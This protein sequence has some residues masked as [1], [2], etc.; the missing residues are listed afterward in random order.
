M[1]RSKPTWK[2]QCS[3]FEL[4]QFLLCKLEI[5]LG[6]FAIFRRSKYLTY[7]Q[8][9]PTYS[10]VYNPY[11]YI[12]IYSPYLHLQNGAKFLPF[13]R[14][15]GFPKERHFFCGTAFLEMFQIIPKIWFCNGDIAWPNGD[16]TRPHGETFLHRHFFCKKNFSLQER[17]KLMPFGTTAEKSTTWKMYKW[18]YVHSGL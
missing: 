18:W 13:D 3:H 8:V 7:L 11:V 6:G 12:Y 10:M 16:I 5:Y 4:E 14:K 2:G 1:S 9:H 15:I 17:L